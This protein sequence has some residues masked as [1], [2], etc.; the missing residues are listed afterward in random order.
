MS[1]QQ[2]G[3]G[4]T[5]RISIICIWNAILL[6][7]LVK[8]SLFA[9]KIP[10]RDLTETLDGMSALLS[11][12][13][14]PSS[15]ARTAQP[16]CRLRPSPIQFRG[17][18]RFSAGPQRRRHISVGPRPTAPRPHAPT[19][20]PPLHSP[21]RGARGGLR[22]AAVGAGGGGHLA[23]RGERPERAGARLL[24]MKGPPPGVRGVM[25]RQGDG[26]WGG[27][28]CSHTRP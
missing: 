27:Q 19:S 22:G 28:Q 7:G 15:P 10:P 21:P 4:R 1:P 18:V 23:R 3:G 17:R 8:F 13:G 5:A 6:P 24:F 25:G 14:E 20:P 9:I 16:I 2:A 11:P 12:G 26:F